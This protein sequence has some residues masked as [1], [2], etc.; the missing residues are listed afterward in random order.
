MF[1]FSPDSQPRCG[2]IVYKNHGI[3]LYCVAGDKSGFTI[4]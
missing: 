2:N 3:T 1:G 4:A